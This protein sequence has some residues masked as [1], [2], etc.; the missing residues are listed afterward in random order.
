[1][2]DLPKQAGAYQRI[3]SEN[4]EKSKP[5]IEAVEAIDWLQTDH[6]KSARKDWSATR[7]QVE[8]L[9]KVLRGNGFGKSWS[10]V[11]A[12]RVHAHR[13]HQEE[14]Y[15][16]FVQHGADSF[17]HTAVTTFRPDDGTSLPYSKVFAMAKELH[18]VIDK[19][20]SVMTNTMRR[21]G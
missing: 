13:E 18:Q 2:Q 19:T 7:Y 11:V 3:L 4:D 17:D 6:T 1:M 5:A 10:K 20:S 16:A 8:K 21:K 12:A 15:P 14:E 9:S